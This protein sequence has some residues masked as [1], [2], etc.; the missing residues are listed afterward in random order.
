LENKADKITHNEKEEI[1]STSA[2]QTTYMVKLK[3]NM[4]YSHI[5]CLLMALHEQHPK[6][7]SNH[8]H[9]APAPCYH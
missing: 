6:S 7:I 8:Y 4:G 1:I 5:G 9:I 2:V 3:K